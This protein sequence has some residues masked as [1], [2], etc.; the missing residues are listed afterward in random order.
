MAI[1]PERIA[2]Q[3]KDFPHQVSRRTARQFGHLKIENLNVAGMLKNHM[4][5]AARMFTT[6]SE[7]AELAF[8][9]VTRL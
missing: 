4:S 9:T 7:T 3:R 6:G 2:N 8:E 1:R 5:N